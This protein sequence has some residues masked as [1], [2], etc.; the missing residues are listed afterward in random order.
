MQY[1]IRLRKARSYAGI[2]S[3]TEKNPDVYVD[4]KETADAAV[5][6]GY[7]E[8]IANKEPDT[9]TSA[10]GTLDAE[11]LSTMTTDNL[12]RLAADMGIDTTGLK[13]KADI[14]AAIIAVEVTPGEE[15]EAEAENDNEA[16]YGDDGKED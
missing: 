1:H 5:A 13:K 6:T 14:I 3:A 2:V 8:L 12:K 9:H 7:F 11:Q 16:D 15:I 4:D 10:P